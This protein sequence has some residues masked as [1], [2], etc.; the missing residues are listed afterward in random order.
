MASGALLLQQ[1]QQRRRTV[2]RAA[3]VPD[4]SVSK[5]LPHAPVGSCRVIICD[6]VDCGGLGSGAVLLEIEELIA[7]DRYAGGNNSR[8]LSVAYGVC[9][10]QCANAPVVNVHETSSCGTVCSRHHSKVDTPERCFH[11]LEDAAGRAAA[12]GTSAACGR[13]IMLRRAHGLRWNA[14]RQQARLYRHE[15]SSVPRSG[16]NRQLVLAL[17]AEA[18]AVRDDSVRLARAERRAARLAITL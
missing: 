8:S 11:V 16:A 7:E 18:R 2:S 15:Q 4:A 12:G 3:D 17:Q 14:L 5:P 6:G 9:T 10:L 13:E 1:L